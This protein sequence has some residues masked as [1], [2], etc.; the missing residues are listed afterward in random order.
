MLDKR[1]LVVEDR[2][3]QGRR[4]SLHIR[5]GRDRVVTK[6]GVVAALRVFR[7]CRSASA[8]GHKRRLLGQPKQRVEDVGCRAIAVAH[9]M[10]SYQ[11]A[12]YALRYF[13]P[14][15][16]GCRP[17]KFWSN[18]RASYV[19]EPP[20]EAIIAPGATAPGAGHGLRSIE[21]FS[22]AGGLALGTHAAGFRHELLAEWNPE[23]VR[24]LRQNSESPALPG[25]EH[26]RVE[27]ADVRQ[28][29]FTKYDGIDLVAGGPPCQPFSIGGKHNGDGDT[30]DMIP[31]F[32]RAVREARP[33]AFMFENVRGLLRPG[34]RPYFEYVLLSLAHAGAVRG[35]H[36]GWEDHRRRLRALGRC[37]DFR[38]QYRVGFK[39]LNAAD[40]GVPQIRQRVFV[41]GFRADLGR[42][43]N[44]PHSTHMPPPSATASARINLYP[45][46]PLEG[47]ATSAWLTVRDALAGLPEPS[48]DGES[49]IP[50]HRLQLGARPYQGHTGSPWD[51]PAKTLKAGDHGVPGGENMLRHADGTVRYFTVREAARLQTFPDSWRFSGPWSEAMRQIGNAVPVRLAAVIA[52]AVAKQLR[53]G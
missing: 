10:T 34:F 45:E 46:L 36:E 15:M 16:S 24:T 1:G 3:P 40:Y 5:Y 49:C 23:A 26:W 6:E 21:L 28:M 20:A 14:C 25:L 44:F 22:G 7:G 2:H 31:Q 30:R 48:P 11:D 29:H 39:L 18:M 50:D 51:Y 35:E 27:Q 17:P 37:S 32:V 52:G 19:S 47:C 53:D 13:V 41:V 4:E 8:K 12:C 38:P 43:F 9:A 33:R 42:G